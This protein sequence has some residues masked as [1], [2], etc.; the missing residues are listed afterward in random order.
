MENSGHD[1]SQTTIVIYNLHLYTKKNNVFQHSSSTLRQRLADFLLCPI[2][3]SE[4]S[5]PSVVVSFGGCAND[6]T[7]SSCTVAAFCRPHNDFIMDVRSARRL[8]FTLVKY[9]MIMREALLFRPSPLY[10]LE[11][12]SDAFRPRHKRNVVLTQWR[13]LLFVFVRVSYLT[14]IEEQEIV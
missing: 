9:I 3:F 13:F 2:Q 5:Q 7:K 11:P 14:D 12:R 1:S 4:I 10:R 6:S 8:D